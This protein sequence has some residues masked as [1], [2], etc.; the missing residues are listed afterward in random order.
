[1]TSAEWQAKQVGMADKWPQPE[2]MKISMPGRSHTAYRDET[3]TVV[4]RWSEE[5]R[6]SYRPHAK[7][8]GTKSH[9]RYENYSKARTVGEALE[10]GSF[11]ADWCWD[12][13]RGFIRVHGPVRDEPIDMSKVMDESTLTKVDMIIHKWYRRELAKN[14]GLRY[15][16]LAVG[17][18]SGESTLMRA[19]RLVAQ[20]EAGRRLAAAAAGGRRVR[21]EDVER[22]LQEWAFA[23]NPY[24]TNVMKEGQTWVWSDTLGLLIDRIGDIHITSATTMYPAVMRIIVQWLRERLPPEAAKFGFTS[25]NLNCN[26][27]AQRHRDKN[28]FGPSLIKAFGSFTGGELAYWPEDDKTVKV[29]DMPQDKKVQVQLRDGLMMFNGNCAHAVNDFQGERFSVVYFTLGCHAKA[30]PADRAK[31]EELGVAMPEVD[32]D[33]RL[34][35]RA[36][37]GFAG[38]Q[39]VAGAQELPS[40]RYWEN[41]AMEAPPLAPLALAPLPES[42]EGGSS[43]A[44]LDPA[45]GAAE[46]TPS[47]RAGAKGARAKRP[48]EAAAEAESPEKSARANPG[49]EELDAGKAIEVR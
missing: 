5:T 27:A 18:G 32:A 19:H 31:L 24:R 7:S 6:I 26:Y 46:G 41:A 40:M 28:N 29:D 1:M 48:A 12:Y 44:R 25:I 34:L 16:D 49:A 4:T 17:K 43:R 47:K 39:P 38:Q 36:P 10:L 35:L 2:H 15:E 23:R 3:Y 21:D 8:P 9:V 45:E 11:P 14:L 42:V 22:T 13:E 33:P 30:K 20:R 37:R